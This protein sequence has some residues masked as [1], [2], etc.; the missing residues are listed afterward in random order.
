M[1]I[2]LFEVNVAALVK[3]YQDKGDDGVTAYKGK[4]DV[5]PPFQREFVYDE[6]QRAMVIDT[7]LKGHPLNVMYWA[8]RDKIEDGEPEYEII[9]GQHQNQ[10]QEISTAGRDL[11]GLQTAL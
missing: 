7:I 1:D 4:L 6:K 11:P 3:G 8:V 5:R 9:D 2:T 10:T